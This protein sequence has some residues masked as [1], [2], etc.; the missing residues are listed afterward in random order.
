ME[1]FE[2]LRTRRSIRG[3]RSEAIPD[4]VFGRV[5]EAVRLAPSACNLQPWRF[6]VLKSAAR[7]ALACEC[8]PRGDWLQQAPVI[9]LALGNRTAAWKRLNGTSAH[10]IDVSIALEHLVLAAAA[11]GL[12]TCWICAFDQDRAHRQFAL[13]SEWEVVAMTP[14]GYP[15]PAV[16]LRPFSRNAMRDIIEIS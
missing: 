5:F 3:Y 14:L 12:G 6:L 9:V 7:R 4:A 11:E 8:Y 13:S 16:P 1:F 10:V 15:D 2:V